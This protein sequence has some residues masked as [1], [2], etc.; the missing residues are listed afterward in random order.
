VEKTDKDD[1]KCYLPN[2]FQRKGAVTK[3]EPMGPIGPW[4]T[5]KTSFSPTAGMTGIRPVVDCYSI[6]QTN[7]DLWQQRNAAILNDAKDLYE[8]SAE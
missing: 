2:P 4:A 8:R 1:D 7:I 5:G 3:N 6:T